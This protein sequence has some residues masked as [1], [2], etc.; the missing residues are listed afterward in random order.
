MMDTQ[1][2]LPVLGDV[3]TPE[4]QP[5][6]TRGEAFVSFH[7]ANPHVLRAIL[8]LARQVPHGGRWS[9]KGAFEVLRFSGL[10]TSGDPFK[11][12]NNMTASYARLVVA[13]APELASLFELR[14]MEDDGVD[15]EGEA[16]RWHLREIAGRI[17]AAAGARWPR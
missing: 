12:N 17:E 10:R 9:T 2:P 1:L 4:A 8:V 14:R 5:E 3:V 11:L 7:R 6:Q 13:V 16:R 15:F